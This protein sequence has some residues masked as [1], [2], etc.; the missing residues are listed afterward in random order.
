MQQ[1]WFNK[2]WFFL[3]ISL[4]LMGCAHSGKNYNDMDSHHHGSQSGIEGTLKRMG[5][6]SF[7]AFDKE[8]NGFVIDVE[9]GKRIPT[10][11]ERAKT[12]DPCK[13]DKEAAAKGRIRILKEQQ[14][15]IIDFVGSCCRIYINKTTGQEEEKCF[16]KDPHP[17]SICPHP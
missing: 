14:Y 10:C 13:F 7:L 6:T 8:G 5:T 4:I 1:Q 15:K 2:R 12:N 9:T 16:P 17:Q 3:L 11:E